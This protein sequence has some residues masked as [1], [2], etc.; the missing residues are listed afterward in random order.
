MAGNAD[1]VAVLPACASAGRERSTM[2]KARERKR[3]R[4]HGVRIGGLPP[5]PVNAITDVAGVRTAHVTLIRDEPGHAVRTGVTAILPHGGNPFREKV[6]AAAYVV[7][8]FGKTAGL[9]QIEEL[10]TLEAPILLTNTFGVGAALEGGLRAMMEQDEGVGGEAGS[11]NIVAA[12][13][14][15]RYLNDMRGLHVRP[16]HAERAVRLARGSA[17]GV[18]PEEGAVGAGTGMV[19]FGYKGGIGSSSRLVRTEQGSGTVGALV[20]SN[21]GRRADLTLL[22]RPVGRWLE[23]QAAAARKDASRPLAG[24]EQGGEGAG[25]GGSGSFPLSQPQPER[26]EDGSIIIVLA[27]DLPLDARQL[28]RLAKRAAF[29]LARTGSAADHGSGDIVVAF[30]TAERV[31][32]EP[33][34]LAPAR[35]SLREDGPTLADAFRAA[36]EATEEAIWNSL[37]AGIGMTGQEGRRVEALPIERIVR[38]LEG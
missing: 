12:E 37:C 2:E 19:C 22:G 11:I 18:P 8:G 20:L 14:N 21:F 32:H 27:T 7:N 25:E 23:E 6:P 3:L 1:A 9:V 24:M 4:E 15:D 36:A 33:D 29:G 10:G 35:R 31:A 28:K 34:E 30:S 16:E 5:G 38:W 13:C 26:S 17:E